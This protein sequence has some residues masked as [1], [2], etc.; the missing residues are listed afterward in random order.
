MDKVQI[1]S[2]PRPGEAGVRMSS[3][4]T[5]DAAHAS[6][7]LEH[8][9][10]ELEKLR[11]LLVAH[12]RRMQACA[13]QTEGLQGLVVSEREVEDILS[14]PIGASVSG[15]NVEWNR[16]RTPSV[17]DAGIVGEYEMPLR[18]LARLFRLTPFDIA[19]IL[20]ALAADLDLGFG[21]LYAFLQDDV[22]KKQPSVDLILSLLCDSFGA[23][24]AQRQRFLSPAP[25]IDWSLLQ[26]FEDS[27]H[28]QS[29]LLAKQCQVDE[30]IV[31]FL[32]GSS[33][34]DARLRPY[35]GC[36][37]P[38]LRLNHLAMEGDITDRLT[39]LV[40]IKKH[41]LLLYFQGPYGV[42][43]RSM[44]A[45]LANDLGARLLTVDVER[46]SGTD[47]P[48]FERIVRLMRREALL[49]N[50][51]LCWKGFDA[52]LGDEKRGW[53]QVLQQQLQT[54][55]GVSILT[56]EG[57]WE[58]SDLSAQCSFQRIEF[59]RPTHLDRVQIWEAVL[60]MD[61]RGDDVDLAALSQKF[62]LTGGQ[63]RDAAALARD[64]A[65]GGGR[66]Q[67]GVAL[68]ELYEACRSQS[69]RK[70]AQLAR[71]IA[72]RRV[73]GDLVL[74][75]ERLQHLREIC[76]AMKFRS[77]VYDQWGFDQKLSLGKGLNILFAGP[78]GTGKTLA[79][80]I[81]AGELGLEL[82]KIDLSSVV[83][84]YIGET[85]KNLSRIFTEAEASNG[86][87]F[88][89][90]ADALFGKRTEVRDSHDRYANIE[91]NYL[92]Q[93]M[94]EYDGVV[95]LATNFRR[96]MDDAF[97]RRMHFTVEFPFPDEADRLRIW[98]K[99]WPE[100]TP[101]SS[102]LDLE[103]MARQ[104]EIAGAGIRNIALASAFLAASNGGK[105]NMAHLLH[106]ARR[107]LQKSGK[108]ISER[109]FETG[110]AAARVC[111]S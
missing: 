32:L 48:I 101:R 18:T 60:P 91:V 21:R 99:S 80:E 63:I 19:S 50:A 69:S 28:L 106:G 94:E 110:E 10:A 37:S 20:I 14:R 64:S 13:R 57:S 2:E 108:V 29:T 83:S 98:E 30:R 3:T 12:F 84:K 93:K 36:C 41:G 52:L 59:A 49:Q 65:W 15:A 66:V 56:G 103:F 51:V 24:M 1:P 81:M 107:E 45:A 74:P 38:R 76:N 87:L 82:Y 53:L 17:L 100:A 72:P 4:T 47:L 39:A 46:L 43:K 70:L 33:E 92:L 7:P 75:T 95:I 35:S 73:W 58:P 26:L 8:M 88:F 102:D 25:L 68:A 104:F 9:V 42:G 23:K 79:A 44:A 105:V 97:V 109:E 61:V 31:G 78:S 40:Q 86:I 89:D 55:A 90:E 85:E 71:K 16:D 11:P 77:V 111:K 27:T 34:I 22:T 67:R 96:N 5:V 54:H 62:R 6:T